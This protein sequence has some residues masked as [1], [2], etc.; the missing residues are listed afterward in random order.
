MGG[1]GRRVEGFRVVEM[2]SKTRTEWYLNEYL[3]TYD[4]SN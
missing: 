3:G 1:Y 4:L 2:L